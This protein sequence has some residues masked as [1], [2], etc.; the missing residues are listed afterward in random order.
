[1]TSL[2]YEN[3]SRLERKALQSGEWILVRDEATLRACYYNTK[4]CETTLDL[5][6]HLLLQPLPVAGAGSNTLDNSSPPKILPAPTSVEEQL[7]AARLLLV[8]YE[9]ELVQL[10]HGLLVSAKD[11]VAQA[12]AVVPVVS[13]RVP[14]DAAVGAAAEELR[15][16]RSLNQELYQRVVLDRQQRFVCASCCEVS[17]GSSM[18]SPLFANKPLYPEQQANADHAS[19]RRDEAIAA[20]MLHSVGNRT[21]ASSNTITTHRG[22]PD[23]QD[24]LLFRSRVDQGLSPALSSVGRPQYLSPA[25]MKTN[26]ITSH[27][28]LRT[29]SLY[30]SILHEAEPTAMGL[31]PRMTPGRS[32]AN[33][34]PPGLVLRAA[35]E[36]PPRVSLSTMSPSRRRQ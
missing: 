26:Y 12:T 4:T 1:M 32:I 8:A 13:V 33:E 14:S 3:L 5:K 17:E 29:T 31:V 6:K 36:L 28:P 2:E 10:R 21:D 23:D 19:R 20:R 27:A 24:N 7:A 15:A 25:F 34:T 35:V 9:K 11:A 30:P 18:T 22:I 16:L